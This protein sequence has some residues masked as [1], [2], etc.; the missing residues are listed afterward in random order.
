[1]WDT[2]LKMNP[3]DSS[4]A[5]PS[6]TGQNANILPTAHVTAAH[7]TA[8]TPTAAAATVVQSAAIVPTPDDPVHQLVSTPNSPAPE[9]QVADSLH[10]SEPAEIQ[11]TGSAGRARTTSDQSSTKR[12]GQSNT[13]RSGHSSTKRSGKKCSAQPSR[14]TNQLPAPTSHHN[15]AVVWGNE[16]L[17]RHSANNPA[18]SARPSPHPANGSTK[19]RATATSSSV[20]NNATSSPNGTRELLELDTID[21]QHAVIIYNL[22]NELNKKE[23]ELNKKEE[24]ID[25]L[26]KQLRSRDNDLNNPSDQNIDIKQSS[27]SLVNNITV[28]DT[29][30]GPTR[31]NITPGHHRQITPEFESPTKIHITLPDSGSSKLGSSPEDIID[32]SPEID[33]SFGVLTSSVKIYSELRERHQRR[34]KENLNAG[35]NDSK[36]N[37]TQTS[38][39]TKSTTATNQSAPSNSSSPQDFANQAPQSI[40]NQS[41]Q[42]SANH[43][44]KTN[45]RSPPPKTNRF[46]ENCVPKSFVPFGS[47]S[48]TDFP[49]CNYNDVTTKIKKIKQKHKKANDNME[50]TIDNFA[51]ANRFFADESINKIEEGHIDDEDKALQKGL[52]NSFQT[53]SRLARQLSK[54]QYSPMK[55]TSSMQ[56]KKEI[57]SSS[58]G[59]PRYEYSPQLRKNLA[60]AQE[61][62]RLHTDDPSS[63]TGNI[64]ANTLVNYKV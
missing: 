51:D 24:E 42:H 7:V 63:S 60:A 47:D 13:K 9:L 8:S 62:I 57:P 37:N 40:A 5:S 30:N 17:T 53:T 32:S 21:A 14:P 15:P 27:S 52:L 6:S 41:P 20:K 45:A 56:T 46:H 36:H 34:Q 18:H 59:G 3:S 1:M 11:I 29:G 55:P 50:D 19:N 23:N 35:N 31:Q 28:A 49:A 54:K 38:N 26:K 33:S 10:I 22:K 12:S 61:M 39:I 48:K 43:C 2:C 4:D 16:N 25:E 64:T 58:T 44:P